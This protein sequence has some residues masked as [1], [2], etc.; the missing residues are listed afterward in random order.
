MRAHNLIYLFITLFCGCVSFKEPCPNPCAVRTDPECDP[1]KALVAK[2]EYPD[3]VC[4]A[5][6]VLASGPPRKLSDGMPTDFYDLTLEEAVRIGLENSRI[7]KDLGGNVLRTPQAIGSVFD[8]SITMSQPRLGEEAA[9]AAFDAQYQS[10]V[11][12]NAAN[13]Q[14]NNSTLG[15]GG[16]QV[17]TDGFTINSQMSKTAATGTQFVV[18]QQL[19]YLNSDAPF[20]L[21]PSIYTGALRASIRHPLLQGSG[22]EFNR[23]AGPSNSVDLSITRGVVLAR[24]NGD[25]TV[26]QFERGVRDYIRDLETAYW[27]LYFAYRSL[28]A[29]RAGRDASRT[30]FQTVRARYDADIQG[31]EADREAQARE[32]MYQFENM[33]LQ[34]L[35]GSPSGG[36]TGV[37]LAER[38]LRRMMGLPVSD[39]SLLR[40]VDEP[41]EAPVRFD[42]HDCLTDA[43]VRR[44]EL[45]EQMWRVK[46]RELEM[47]AARNF[48]LPR[49]DAV[50]ALSSNGFGNQLFGG[51]G[52]NSTPARE[53]F[54][55]DNYQTQL[56]LQFSMPIGQRREIAGVRHAKLNLCREKAVLRDQEHL[57]SHN[58][59]TAF[60][61]V[62][63]AFESIRI[64]QSRLEA[65]E[66]VIESRLALFDAGKVAIDTLLES[67]RR[68]VDAETEYFQARTDYALAL[69]DLHFQKG[70]LLPFNGVKLQEG[71][72]PSQACQQAWYERRRWVAK[73]SF[74]GLAVEPRPASRG[75]YDAPID[76]FGVRAVAEEEFNE[77][78]DASQE[79][80]G[81][82]TYEPLVNE[83]PMGEVRTG[84]TQNGGVQ[85]NEL[86]V[87]EIP[88]PNGD[89]PMP[90]WL[91]M[92]ESQPTLES[93]P[94]LNAEP[95]LEALPTFESPMA[96]LLP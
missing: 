11:I 62:E 29:V 27:Q 48:L 18:G 59:G 13:Q 1:C 17:A 81:Y 69:R 73:N 40:P 76:G 90:N 64:T 30:T 28:D 80:L 24:I 79:I 70:T 84:E 34:A 3:A 57:I 71:P 8:P 5:Q 14:F 43:L 65:A 88:P 50:A 45:R 21:F 39:E 36:R 93:S 95:I 94:L 37:F 56:G 25:I 52:P 96:P 7:L 22:V 4:S 82:P 23:I 47:I 35:N 58:L 53:V 60:V 74:D 78:D 2:I 72:W 32:Q 61:A 46:Q 67:E 89:Q 42:W 86:P 91:P 38:Q 75:L 16:N 54:S 9:L 66:D 6:N 19:D 26:A 85:I 63:T 49:L 15:G 33:M 77:L 44:V 55:F 41:T 92:Q 87:G 83:L 68:R 31:G 20:N 10:S 12:Y 51:S